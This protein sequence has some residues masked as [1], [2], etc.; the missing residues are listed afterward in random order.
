MQRIRA[1]IVR[2]FDHEESTT[3]L[4]PRGTLRFDDDSAQ[5]VRVVLELHARP[6]ARDELFAE[7]AERTDGEVPEKPIDD[8]LALLERH[9][10]LVAAPDRPPRPRRLT[11]RVVL[12]ISGAV[13]AVDAALLVRGLHSLGCDVRIALTS[14]A[15]RFVPVAA[16]EA[17]VHHQ[18]WRDLW[19]RDERVPVPH[20]ALAEWAELMVV[21][22][23]SA[24]TIARIA[25]GDCSDLVSAIATA[26]LA[27]VVIAPSM[28]DAMLGAPAVQDNLETL[29]VHGRYVVHGALGV[30]VAHRPADRVPM[31]GPAA[32]PPA[33]LDI[34]R[35]LLATEVGVA[36]ATLP[37]H[38]AGW[39]RLWATTPVDRLPWTLDPI[40]APLT[41]ALDRL[42]PKDD[43]QRRLL[44]L[45]T[46]TGTVAIEAARRGYRVT[47]TDIAPT[48][49]ARARER[50][51]ELPIL[52]ALDDIGAP[53][54]EGTFDV[55][56]DRGLLHCLP[57]SERAT[58]AT[59]VTARTAPGGT[60]L[61][62]AHHGP[63]LA[64]HPIDEPELRAL[65]P[66][67]E[68]VTV[69][70]TSLSGGDARLFELRAPGEL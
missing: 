9:Q 49:L 61:L 64:T 69:T 66:G 34:V 14:T 20:I 42:A 24:T 65:L 5:L 22:P 40:D 37:T 27:P 6:I 38:A 53:H 18:V 45:G 30:E 46:G 7:L 2:I 13:A 21:W 63:G 11:R 52:F 58:Y 68:L 59:A 60:L 57:P 17:L 70:P 19:Q 47:A 33:M 51:G 36:R 3:I 10:V 55:V 8:L 39:E 28:N 50:A 31:F 16:L 23:A 56:V 25:I 4:G 32:P 26:T 67:F 48:A 12:G 43:T 62:V 29:R 54:L 15:H 35:H 41:D 1:P 44:D